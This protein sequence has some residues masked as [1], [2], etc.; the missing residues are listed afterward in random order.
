MIIPHFVRFARKEPMAPSSKRHPCRSMGYSVCDATISFTA[1]IFLPVPRV[2]VGSAV[3]RLG[4]SDSIRPTY[5]EGHSTPVHRHQFPLL[6]SISSTDVRKVLVPV[7][8]TVSVLYLW[9]SSFPCHASVLHAAP[10]SVV[11]TTAPHTQPA[12]SDAQPS[13][14][15]E[16]RGHL[17]WLGGLDQP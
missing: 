8:V 14:Q 7:L 16:K 3:T 5:T 9:C 6:G 1:T 13:T 12:P 17:M 15:V 10:L 2:T 4:E 11:P